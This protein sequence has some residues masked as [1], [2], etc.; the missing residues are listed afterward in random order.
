MTKI[1]EETRAKMSK[2]HTGML[3][4]EQAKQKLSEFRTGTSQTDE[5]R[6]KISASQSKYIYHTPKG[7]FASYKEA[8]KANN[9]EPHQVRFRSLSKIWP[10]FYRVE[11][12][13]NEEEVT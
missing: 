1:S 11:K 4:K 12:A 8:T 6:H 2:A 3:H 9:L 7:A 5:T 13:T 10:G